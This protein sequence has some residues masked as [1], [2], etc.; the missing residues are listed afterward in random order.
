VALI[1]AMA[2]AKPVV[3]T[4]VGGVADVVDHERTGLLVPP[5]DPAALGDAMLR[6]A[7]N[8]AERS[9]MGAAGRQAVVSRFSTTR[10][11]DDIDRLYATALAQKRD[12]AGR[13]TMTPGAR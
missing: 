13:L 3:A 8:A 11:V 1:E 4:R 9:S 10:L 12:R 2:A 5:S 7:G 6:L